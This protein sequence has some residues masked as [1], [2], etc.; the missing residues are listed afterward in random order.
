MDVDTQTNTS[1]VNLDVL[2]NV[3]V[4]LSVEVGRAAMT[5][6]ELLETAEGSVVKL[7]RLIDEPLDIL[8]ND[9]PIAQGVVVTQ[10]G[11][12]GI[13]ITDIISP[14]ERARN[15]QKEEQLASD[16]QQEEAQASDGG[17]AG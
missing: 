13:Q 4:A 14:H 12:F 10:D 3:P 16:L 7:S 15:L 17:E 5:I 2:L 8:V 11:K 9:A 6:G 1:E